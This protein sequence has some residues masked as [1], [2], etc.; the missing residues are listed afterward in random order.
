MFPPI[1]LSFGLHLV[2]SIF[3][4]QMLQLVVYFIRQLCYT[5][6][7]GFYCSV[8]ERSCPLKPKATLGLSRS[9][10]KQNN[11]LKASETENVW[12]WEGLQNEVIKVR[13][14]K[15]NHILHSYLT[16]HNCITRR[17]WAVYD[18]YFSPTPCRRKC[19][20]TNKGQK[21]NWTHS[22]SSLQPAFASCHTSQVHLVD[23]H[24]HQVMQSSVGSRK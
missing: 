18:K 22:Y 13:W 8:T 6:Q 12:R 11:Q 15:V 1:F 4:C 2:W 7:R 17:I 5:D 16:P 19:K 21:A 10:N 23:E 3:F 20:T 14:I 9:K 24:V